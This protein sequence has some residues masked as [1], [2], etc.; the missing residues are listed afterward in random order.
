MLIVLISILSRV[1]S[2][3]AIVSTE[4]YLRLF[5]CF[6]PECFL[7]GNHVLNPLIDIFVCSCIVGNKVVH[8][9]IK[10]FIIID[11]V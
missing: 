11:H 6:F 4:S 3:F 5:S 7:E 8:P 10:S 2:C 9:E 1:S